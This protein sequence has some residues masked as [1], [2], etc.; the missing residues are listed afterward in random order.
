MASS[1]Y[2]SQSQKNILPE[3]DYCNISP[4]DLSSAACN[5]HKLLVLQCLEYGLSNNFK[6]KDTK[7]LFYNF[8]ILE[9][10]KVLK[11]TDHRIIFIV[12]R[13]SLNHTILRF[14]ENVL[15]LLPIAYI[16]TDIDFDHFLNLAKSRSITALEQIEKALKLKKKQ[17]I[18]K[19]YDFLKR[20]E[21]TFLQE[22]Y[23]KDITNKMLLWN[24]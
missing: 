21:L 22:S 12:C 9:I 17:K 4:V 15:H 10:F 18:K 3:L 20:E 19:F 23:F 8:F 16:I 7:R 5:A 11:N 24:K 13:K 14:V 1:T 6:S 2:A